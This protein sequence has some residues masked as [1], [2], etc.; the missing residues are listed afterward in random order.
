MESFG[1]IRFASGQAKP[2]AQVP[3]T[4]QHFRAYPLCQSQ[5]KVS[6]DIKTNYRRFCE[7]LRRFIHSPIIIASIERPSRTSPGAPSLVNALCSVN[8]SHPTQHKPTQSLC[9]AKRPR[10]VPV[11][12][13]SPAVVEVMQ[14]H[15]PSELLR[16]ASHGAIGR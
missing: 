6:D 12:N 2:S 13:G 14:A 3:A 15:S 9:I 5:G 10:C 4:A 11:D 8:S 7:S 16:T 1:T